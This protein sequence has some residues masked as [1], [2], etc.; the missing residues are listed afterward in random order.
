MQALQTATLNPARFL[1]RLATSG[2]IATGKR[3]ELVLLDANPLEDIHNTTKIYA[4]VINGQLL[5]R[6]K[7]DSLLRSAKADLAAVH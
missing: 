5:D 1:K 2:T 7:L 6:N 3:A 4:V